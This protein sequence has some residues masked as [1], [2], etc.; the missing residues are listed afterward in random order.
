MKKFKEFFE[1]NIQWIAIGA[2]ALY[3]LWMV[4]SF[5][6]T[7]TAWQIPVGGEAKSPGEVDESVEKIAN[8]LDNK[9]KSGPKVDIKVPN[10]QTAVDLT[11]KKLPDYAIAWANSPTQDVQIP[12]APGTPTPTPTVSGPNVPQPPGAP[13]VVELPKVPPAGDLATAQGRSNVMIR[14]PRELVASGRA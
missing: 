11:P 13:K 5:V 9:I 7:N 12:Q 14:P 3:L 1:Q 2:G 4:Y 6:L 10:F 8:Q